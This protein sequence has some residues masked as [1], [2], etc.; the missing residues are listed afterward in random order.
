MIDIE[1]F[2][3]DCV[4]A[5][6]EDRAQEAVKQVLPRA[7]HDP[8]AMLAAVGEPSKAELN[9]LLRSE[10]LT[11]FAATW[12][13][14]MNLMP[15]NHKMWALIGLLHGPRRQH[16]VAALGARRDGVRRQ[17]PVRG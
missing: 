14:N 5:K 16:P 17:L 12:T 1:Q 10:T 4:A 15:H 9:V 13:P 6:K 11:I 3:A 8:R 7:V 2:V